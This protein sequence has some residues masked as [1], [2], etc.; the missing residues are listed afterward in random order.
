MVPGKKRSRKMPTVILRSGKWYRVPSLVT[1]ENKDA[2][3]IYH[4]LGGEKPG[5][6]EEH[7]A[8]KRFGECL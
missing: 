4:G 6:L 1:K 5:N 8:S 3:L 2:S 7:S